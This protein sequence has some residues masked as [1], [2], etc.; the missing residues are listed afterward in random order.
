M[1]N[2][3]H[4]TLPN[5]SAII[6]RFGGIRPMSSKTGIPVTTIQGWKKRDAIP[7]ARLRD[8]QNAAILYR[9]DIDDL[10]VGSEGQ[11]LEMKAEKEVIISIGASQSTTATRNPDLEQPR[12]K[13]A[14]IA[15]GVI[16]FSAA[17][18]GA[19]FAVTPEVRKLTA[20]EQRLKDLEAEVV[21]L[22]EQQQAAMPSDFEKQLES[23]KSKVGSLSDQAKYYTA[24]INDLK[25]GTMVERVGKLEG[26]VSHLLG[27][28]N[29]FGI[30][31]MLSKVETMQSSVGGA[32]DLNMIMS[33]LIG[34]GEMA[35]SESPEQITSAFE[36]LRQSDPKIAA[37][38]KDIAP[39]DMRAAVMLMGMAQLRSSLSRNNAS[40]EQDL[41]ILK[42]TA[43]KDDPV[44][45]A[46]IDRL[47]PKAKS[48][49]LT[50]DGLSKQLRGLTGDIVAASLS[51]EDVSVEDKAL[52]RLGDMIKVEK[53]GKQVSGTDTQRRIA[54]A[55][56]MLDAGD[57]EG[58]VTLLNGLQGPAAEKAKPF[59]EDAQATMMGGQLQQLLGKN[60]LGSLKGL[61]QN[62]GG[63]VAYTTS[64]GG[65][66]NNIKNIIPQ[67]LKPPAGQ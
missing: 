29:A 37:T 49:I 11:P 61:V 3:A 12:Y 44:L 46:A 21:R 40:F 36:K 62:G 35:G 43:A 23:L 55:Q 25:T 10:L 19:V 59:L 31:N 67:G 16:I 32:A 64:G 14:L 45:Q 6:D 4:D 52:A 33:S 63:G 51:G 41:K 15:A 20:Q 50:P 58:A 13:G 42:M 8:I 34:E 65:I 17:A 24:A 27:Q 60:I 5:A 7:L 9:I 56:K 18:L 2:E 53:G 54:D 57:V 22:Q 47:A 26:H 38:F 28:A 48:G 66:V 1:T 39:E 30:Q